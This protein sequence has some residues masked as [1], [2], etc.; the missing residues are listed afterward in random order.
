M[1]HEERL[2]IVAK[3]A[4]GKITPP[5]AFMERQVW[6]QSSEVAILNQYDWYKEK[7]LI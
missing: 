7:G 6:N 1:T 3:L 5:I 4:K 2:K